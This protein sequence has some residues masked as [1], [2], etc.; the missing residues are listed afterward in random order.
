MS[1]LLVASVVPSLALILIVD[2][3]SRG[4]YEAERLTP[5]RS[6]T[7]T[8]V[9]ILITGSTEDEELAVV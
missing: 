9:P 5:Q 1:T 3:V 6:V 2:V 7:W 8:W 4:R